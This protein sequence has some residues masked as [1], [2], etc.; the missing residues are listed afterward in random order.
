MADKLFAFYLLEPF[1][2]REE[3][4][5]ALVKYLSPAVVSKKTG[6]ER[7]RWG[8]V[9]HNLKVKV[10]IEDMDALL[11]AF[12]EYELWIWK[13][14]V[15]PSKGQISPAYAEADVNLEELKAGSR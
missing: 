6:L 1:G 8:T 15:D 7:R 14:E 9:A 10:R 13:G 11:D 5:R 2:M 12:P 4:I 3:R